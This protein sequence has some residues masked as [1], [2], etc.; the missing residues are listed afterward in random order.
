MTVAETLK[1]AKAKIANKKNW[2][3]GHLAKDK[4]GMP[5][6][7][8]D[9][10]ACKWC[11]VG[12]LRAVNNGDENRRA[13]D[14][15][16]ECAGEFFKTGKDYRSIVDVN[17]TKGHATTLKAFDCAIKKAKKREKAK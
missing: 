5:C 12:A 2:T 1:A 10:R 11:A 4:A 17:D 16:D 3:T 8:L 14:L 6:E 13:R 9:S 15:L 7:V